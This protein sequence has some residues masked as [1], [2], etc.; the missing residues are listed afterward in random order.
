[1]SVVD[2]LIAAGRALVDAGLSPGASGNISAIDGDRILVS[3]TGT[4]LGT[5]SESDFA[6]LDLDGTVTGGAKAS[7]ETP[8]HVGFYRRDP[9]HR[10]VV[11]VHSPQ[12]TAFSCTAPWSDVS[13]VPPLTPYFVMRVGR[14]PLLPY[15]MPSSPQL[16]TD[17]LEEP[18]PFR[19]ALLANHGSVVAGATL[20]E[21][22]ERAIELEEACRIALLTDASTRRELT[23]EQTA[24]LAERWGSPW[25][26]ATVH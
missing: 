14:T 19:A 22:V 15:R 12:A 21:A 20:A 2:E 1:M 25:Q 8:L 7:K 4:S 17:I 3:G 24:E 5:L 9:A 13:A 16:G 6:I 23:P 18:G 10:A 26:A 11:H